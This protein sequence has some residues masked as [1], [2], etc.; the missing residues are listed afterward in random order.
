MLTPILTPEEQ[1]LV[2]AFRNTWDVIQYDALSAMGGK[3][4]GEDAAEM[5]ADY[6]G[7]YG[8]RNPKKAAE[9]EKRICALAPPEFK[10]IATQAFDDEYVL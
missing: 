9:L 2:K 6:I 8:H 3:M 4:R 1:E 7:C 10:K 5:C